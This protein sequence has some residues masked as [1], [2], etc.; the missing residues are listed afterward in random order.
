VSV[1]LFAATLIVAMPLVR[2]LRMRERRIFS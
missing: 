1:A 2:F